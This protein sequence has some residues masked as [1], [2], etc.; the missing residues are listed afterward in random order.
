MVADARAEDNPLVLVNRHFLDATGYGRD[1]VIGRNCRF[2]QTRPDGTRDDDQDGV[3]ELARAAAAGEATHVLLRNYTKAGDLF[4]NELFVTPVHDTDGQVSHFVGVQN[5]V[6]GRVLA[7]RDALSQAALL[8][9]F[10]DSAP[11]VMGVVQ[12]DRAG[13][14]HRTANEAAAELFGRPARGVAGARSG[15]LG[16]PEREAQRWADAVEE[17]ADAGEPVE[18]ETR[19]PWDSEP[20]VEGARL[21]RVVVARVQGQGTAQQGELYSYLGEDVTA[22]RRSEAERRLLAAAVDQ[23]DESILVTSA[24][25][26]GSGPTILYANQAHA[27]LFGYELDEVVGRTPRMYQGPNTDRAELDRIREGLEAGEPVHAETANYR[28]DGSEFLLQWEIAPVTDADGEV[29]H[30]V[31][32]Q[33]DVTERRQLEREVLEVQAREQK[34]MAQELHD[35]LGQV[36]AGSAMMIESV[37]SQLDARGLDK[38]ADQLG[39]AAGYVRD[40]HGQARAIARGLFPIDV[41]AGGLADALEQLTRD[42]AEAYGVE[43][44]FASDGPVT[45]ASRDHAGHLYRIAQEAIANAARH[46]RAGR[47]DVTLA[48]L[49]DGAARLSVEDDGRG[50]PAEALGGDSGL[51]LRTMRSRA[52]RVGGSLD[53]RALDGGGTRVAV[54]FEPSAPEAS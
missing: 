13:L 26:D 28:K 33:R 1:E 16:F 25:V 20:N 47:V 43:C 51:G 29:R 52:E 44:A 37:R 39:R 12:R 10:F 3:R 54:R 17:C 50:I 38:L 7:E 35:G 46:G 32:T 11:A 48:R 45:V 31:G 19:F 41:D 27:R 15:E 14:V 53:I 4:Y 40:G 30:W 24:E 42:A 23:A 6:T 34:R 2:L 21:F 9:A 8:G 36:L 5:D 49:A 18:F 22:S